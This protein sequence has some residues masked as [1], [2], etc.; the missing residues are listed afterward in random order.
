M[1]PS[2]ETSGISASASTPA[3]KCVDQGVAYRLTGTQE[4]KL[5]GLAGHNLEVQ[6]RFK[7]ADD[8][9]AAGTQP[10]DKL[11]A[12]VEI[13]SFREV[14]SPAMNAPAATVPARTPAVEAPRAQ[15]PA[16]ATTEPRTA[17][18]PEPRTPATST[19]A[20]KM[21]HTASSSGL[22]VLIGVLAL[23]SGF[24]LTLLRRRAL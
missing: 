3:G 18:A 1:S 8:V 7:H 23:S 2:S 24:A 19:E 13:V 10:A 12:E 11:P 15:V 21:P 9:P 22:L 6:G 17:A 20:R 14:S 16:P 4:E 5:K